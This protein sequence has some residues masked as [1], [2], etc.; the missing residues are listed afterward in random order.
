[1]RYYFSSSAKQLKTIRDFATEKM[2]VHSGP[3]GCGK[4]RCLVEAFGWYCMRLQE[5]GTVGLTFILAGRTQQAVK[6]NMCNVLTDLFG[7]DFKYTGSHADGK[8]KDA[9]LF[10]Q[11]IYLIGFNDNSSR[12][13]FQG[14]TEIIGILHD[15]CTLCSQEQFDYAIGRLRGEINT[16]QDTED[17]REYIEI[18]D[19]S[20]YK[21]TVKIPEGTVS[22]WYCGSCNPDRPNHFIKQ[23]IDSG[24]IHNVKWYRHDA[25][26]KGSEEYY[27][28]LALQ[29][30]NN[31]AFFARYLKG[32]WTSADRMIY[33]MFQ[34][35]VH[36]INTID[37]SID[38]KAFKRNFISI[39]Y[40]GDH[41]TAIIL[42]S[43]NFQGIYIISKE[44]KIRN[45]APSDICG[46]VG[47][48]IKYVNDEGGVINNIF[49]D[50]SAKALKDELTKFDIH[51]DN[52]MNSH[53]D[54]IGFIQ[55]QFS[56][57]KL[58]ILSN[59]TELLGEIYSYHYKDNNSGK[60]EV[61]KV[62]DDLVDAMRYGVYTDS[63][64][65]GR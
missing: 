64:V 45:T 10:G 59:C 13:K 6:R 37:F 25:I 63:V 31:P 39:D 53:A 35:H 44:L 12:E 51:Y 24:I 28:K 52:A 55:N 23:Y 62:D 50:P 8:D 38:Y 33:C 3:F 48:F 36:I 30:K 19:N 9:T 26:W 34:P 5:L 40:G 18:N 65:G 11:N 27:N 41:P 43:I 47:K 2:V 61:Y 22:M 56:L 4:T 1:M 42:G 32:Q 16:D 14:I 15:E 60:D 58:F 46:E 57:N 54:G 17:N 29:Y 21:N 7:N 20:I 49:I